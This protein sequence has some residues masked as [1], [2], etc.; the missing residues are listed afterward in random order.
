MFHDAVGGGSR[1]DEHRRFGVAGDGGEG[2]MNSRVV[3]FSVIPW[4]MNRKNGGLLYIRYYYVSIEWANVLVP[5]T[6]AKGMW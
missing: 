2:T 6:H 1:D 5:P 4:E 3:F